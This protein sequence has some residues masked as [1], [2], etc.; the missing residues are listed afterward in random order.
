MNWVWARYGS[1]P[2]ELEAELQSS[3]SSW[4]FDLRLDYRVG[5][6]PWMV[7]TEFGLMILDPDITDEATGNL[8]AP[9]VAH[10]GINAV[11]LRRLA[12]RA[13]P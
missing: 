4:G 13:P 7:G 10:A 6:G 2:P 3:T 9:V 1:L 11:N 5:N 12:R 8:V